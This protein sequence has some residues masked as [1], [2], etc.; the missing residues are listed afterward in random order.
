MSGS[1]VRRGA[2]IGFVAIVSLLPSRAS[3][4]ASAGCP[5]GPD[6]CAFATRLDGWLRTGDYEPIIDRLDLKE[7]ICPDDPE[8]A[9]LGAP[10]PLCEGSRPGERRTGVD[11]IRLG[12]E[13]GAGDPAY[14]RT[15]LRRLGP[16]QPATIGCDS[17]V[18][19][20]AGCRDSFVVVYAAPACAAD[21]ACPARGLVIFPIVLGSDGRY[22]FVTIIGTIV[23]LVG[24]AFVEG[25]T[26]T[27]VA[28]PIVPGTGPF[29][30]LFS[31][32]PKGVSQLP[33][34]G[35]RLNADGASRQVVMPV[36]ALVVVIILGALLDRRR[37]I[38]VRER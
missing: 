16:L 27:R 20:S 10:L 12:S 8:R 19:A 6:A 4:H 15:Q 31:W 30:S 36:L 13:G 7:Y 25:G 24:S 35:R 29:V 28:T 11:I 22:R 37:S 17:V 5:V 21:D 9:G 14:V 3:G 18:R 32:N 38:R 1:S 33:A 34:T 26:S 2:I 23:A